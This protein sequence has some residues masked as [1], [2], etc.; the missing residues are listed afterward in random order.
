MLENDVS[1]YLSQ[2]DSKRRREEVPI[3]DGLF[4]R[5]TGFAPQV[6]SGGMI[7]YGRYDFTYKSGRKGFCFA[8]GFAPRPGTL[9]VYIM[10]GFARFQSV[11]QRLGKYGLSASC[12]EIEGM[13]DV[14]PLVLEELIAAGVKELSAHWPVSAT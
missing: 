14:N 12:L 7:G 13:A 8:T 5:A 3:L 11:L 6:W 1:A 2:I 10:P 9:S 4:Q